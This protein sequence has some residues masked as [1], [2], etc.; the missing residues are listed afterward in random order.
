MSRPGQRGSI[1]RF[2]V[3]LAM[4]WCVGGL[5]GAGAATG[6][7]AAS[8]GPFRELYEELV[9]ID[10]TLSDGSCTIAAEAMARRLQSAGMPAPAM[11]VLA[12][13]DR[14]KSGSLIARLPGRDAKLVPIML[15]AHID[16]V[17]ARRDDWDR[18]P[19]TLVEEDGF[20]YARGASDDK[21]MA[22]IFTDLLVGWQQARYV[23]RRGVTLAL[24]CGE[25]TPNTFNGVSWLL[26]TH[27]EL[28]RAQF[29]LN[30]G[31]GGLLDAAGRP[32]SLDVQAGEKVY[33]DFTLE[34]TQ[35]G[36]HSSRPTRDNAIDRMS[37]AV[38]RLSAH[39]F[40]VSL[41]ETT[42]NYF[43]AQ[44][45]LSPPDIASD[46]RAIVADPGDGAAAA[47]LWTANPTWNG[48]LRTTCVATEFL[49]GH[50]PNALPQ[51]ARVN[52][53][54]RILPGVP[55]EQVRM[56]SSACSRTRRSR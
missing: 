9:E 53:N 12:P 27:P 15:L 8:E 37:A 46:M 32:V 1:S 22:A 55:V 34:I 33:Q 4:A 40:P 30:E 50:A 24:T 36:G 28:M 35:A 13:A 41:N 44:A 6:S 38:S 19:F 43:L 45:E 20:F 10:T 11:Q 17:E 29:V 49:G 31:A 23:P 5:P 25:E 42:R 7:D 26:Q 54:C 3:L 47:R 52:V 2:G 51:R 21:A 39:Q 48:M 18:D 16:V 56:N 14:P